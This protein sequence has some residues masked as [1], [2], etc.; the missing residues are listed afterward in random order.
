[1][2]YRKAVSTSIYDI[3]KGIGFG[4]NGSLYWLMV[5]PDLS[6]MIALGTVVGGKTAFADIVARGSYFL[7][8]GEARGKF[9]NNPY[10]LEEYVVAPYY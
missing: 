3:T 2:A 4:D 7:S 1:M 8:N 10:H 5:L 6:L 9:V